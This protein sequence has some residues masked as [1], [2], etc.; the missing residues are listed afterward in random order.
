MHK[1][2]IYWV[3]EVLIILIALWI[4]PFEIISF[5]IT[6]G[7][8][9]IIIKFK[10]EKKLNYVKVAIAGFI[11]G[12]IILLVFFLL[13]ITV[14]SFS[15]IFNINLKIDPF[16]TSNIYY[17]IGAFPIMGIYGVIVFIFLYYISRPIYVYFTQTNKKISGKF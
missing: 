14:I 3:I 4:R 9:V 17:I 1:Y 6:F 11:S 7:I 2:E 13:Q 8:F 5:I 15:N 16:Y 12:I 10:M